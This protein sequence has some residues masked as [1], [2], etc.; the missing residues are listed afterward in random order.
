MKPTQMPVK[1]GY[2]ELH[3]PPTTN[4]KR[5]PLSLSRRARRLWHRAP[6]H[7]HRPDHVVSLANADHCKKATCC[8]MHPT[9]PAL[10][11]ADLFRWSGPTASEACRPWRYQRSKA[12]SVAMPVQPPERD[13]HY[14]FTRSSA[15]RK[16][17]A[18]LR[19]PSRSSVERSGDK[20]AT[21]PP[22]P[23]TLCKESV[24]PNS[25]W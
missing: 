22:R 14:D 4:T 12:R 21:T 23:T 5:L 17:S 2:T 6:G 10:L 19:K 25:R 11:A 13:A 16:F 3:R 7:P 8:P 1:A 9:R 24:T 15:L 20:I 18:L